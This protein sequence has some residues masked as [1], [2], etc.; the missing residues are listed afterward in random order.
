MRALALWLTLVGFAVP[1][2]GLV[3]QA[4][5]RV[6]QLT[7][8]ELTETLSG[9]RAQ[10]DDKLAEQLSGLQL[11]QRLSASTLARLEAALP[12]PQSQQ[13][14]SLLA[15]RSSFLDLPPSEIPS[16]PSPGVAQQRE[17]M[18]QVVSYVTKI[19][20]KLPDFMA[21]RATRTFE[22]HPAGSNS[23]FGYEPLHLISQSSANVVYR[24][25]KESDTNSKGKKVDTAAAG[26]V[27]WGEFGPIL[28]TVLL[29]AA[30]SQL[31]WGHWE[32][33]TDGPLAVFRYAVP[34]KTSRYEIQFCCVSDSQTPIDGPS[35]NLYR[36]LAAY[37]GEMAVDPA[38]GAIQRITV[39]ADLNPDDPLTNASIAV[40]YAPVDI[41][42]KT[43][44]CPIRSEAI[45]Q[46][47]IPE[48]RGGTIPSTAISQGP[49]LTRLNEVTFDRYHIFRG[50]S[51]ILTEAEAAQ[52]GGEPTAPADANAPATQPAATDQTA[53][54]T[55]ESVP[56]ISPA[57]APPAPAV[58]PAP[59]AQAQPTMAVAAPP[60]PAPENA[61]NAGTPANSADIPVFRTTARQVLVD[62]V[63]DK[64]NGDPVPG[65][66]KSDFSIE[67][68][69]KAEAVDF[70]EEH[71][72]SA[73][74]PV[75]A[76]S[77][78]PMR[79][80]VI[81]NAPVAPPSAALYVFLL[82]SLNTEPQDQVYVRQQILAFLHELDP[83]TEV[84]VFSLGAG[85]RLVQGFTSD[86]AA[87]L[88]A[89]SRKEAER[90]SMAQTRSDNADDAGSIA[91][92]QAMRSNGA[93]ALQGAQANAHAYSFGARASM[94]FEALNALARYLEGIPGR[95][96]LVWFAS[97]FPVVFF[98]TASE[99]DRLKN[100]P[101]LPGYMNRV[102]QTA[103][104]FT[105]SKIAVYP[106][107]RA[108]GTTSNV[109][110]ADSGDAGSAGGA[111]HFGTA[112]S[113]TSSFTAESLGAGS[114]LANMEQLAASTGGR[115]FT[116][117]DID[118]A[119]RKIVHDSDVYYT[120]GYAPANS[121]TDG[122][123]RRID[124][125]IA[126]GKY[127]LAYRQGYNADA[128]PADG[129][130]S[131]DPIA[132]LLGLGLPNATGILYG[133]S[134]AAV[135]QPAGAQ[136]GQAGQNPGLKGPLTRYSVSFVIRAQDL[137]F[138]QAPNGERVAKLV[139]GLKAYGAGG[140]ALNW[141]ATREAAE[142]DP[143]HYEAALKSGIPV[144][145]DL[146]LPAH[147]PAQIVTA[148][149]DWNTNRSGTLEISIHP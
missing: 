145:L 10:A 72:T 123:F 88:A 36:K 22:D 89:V 105:L 104:L 73:P 106:V 132:P 140:A 63:V 99:M 118:S 20:H 115:A 98:P 46:R 119:L 56:A 124:V 39:I 78:P 126:G 97:S 103:D 114:A 62:V 86:P 7:V 34:A 53:S 90:G 136:A 79:P 138:S 131:G 120:L 68:D 21:T 65:L 15:A 82:D 84:A 41:G 44:V 142:L 149:H 125:K 117:N 147:T 76:P 51:R 129:A 109:G 18:A 35:G 19:I 135:A 5:P 29:D 85:L 12:G 87:L 54:S 23:L 3:A 102:K 112:A 43:Y 57:P 94:T 38:T 95:K 148:V 14:L 146:E 80:G 134:A 32:P 2:F 30:K 113:P 121:A 37:H 28:T 144:T 25:G 31:A 101:N 13:E 143:A 108:G 17:I 128:A 93:A 139:I 137:S 11:S 47:H 107:S 48:N 127:K 133:A 96:N 50:E 33:G 111:G 45:A 59:V 100:N 8:A 70:F 110:L 83:G 67:E 141:Q 40:Q 75:G 4:D 77:M 24:D 9:A 71:S 52:A 1:S 66:A 91:T 42:G 64:K 58:S 122:S 55:A 74:A 60:Q 6:R 27:S 26:L 16:N 49:I 61:T 116:T 81:T 69:G 130:P 92:L